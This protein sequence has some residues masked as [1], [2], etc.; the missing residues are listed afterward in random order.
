[1]KKLSE[2]LH[3]GANIT[4]ADSG[5]SYRLALDYRGDGRY[6]LSNISPQG[7]VHMDPATSELAEVGLVDHG[8]D[9]VSVTASNM[10]Q[11]NTV[12]IGPGENRN[13]KVGYRNVTITGTAEDG[14]TLEGKP[15]TEATEDVLLTRYPEEDPDL[16]EQKYLDEG[17]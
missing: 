6:E 15:A 1:M 10:L 11:T 3:F 14:I 16:F 17:D 13:V 2:G 12:R 9:G 7:A 8:N 4:G 5:G